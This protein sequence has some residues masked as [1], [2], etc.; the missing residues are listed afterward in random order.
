[1]NKAV[2]LW[3]VIHELMDWEKGRYAPID[4]DSRYPLGEPFEPV[5]II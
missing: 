3:F 4:S 2:T 5:I 1:M